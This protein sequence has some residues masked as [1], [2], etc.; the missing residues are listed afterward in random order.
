MILGVDASNVRAGGGLTHLRELLAAAEP[1][2]HGFERVVVWGGRTTLDALSPRPWLDARHIAALDRVL[3]AR[4]AWQHVD[5]PVRARL[6]CDVLF[7][8][9]GLALTPFRPRVLVSQNML[10]FE[11]EERARYGHSLARLRFELLA[12]GQAASFASADGV[13][14]LSDYA[15]RVVSERLG[16]AP[17]RS[18]VI[19]HG[20]DARFRCAPRPPRA[21]GQPLEVLYVSTVSPYKH[22]WNVVDAVGSLRAGGLPVSLRLVGGNDFAPSV[23]RMREAI[24]R[25]DP[26]GLG[27]RYEGVLPFEGLHEAYHRADVF[28]FASSCENLPNILIE[29]MAS[30]LP[31]ACSDR[32]PM[33]EVLG[34]AGL[35]FDPESPESIAHAL[36]RLISEPALR[37]RLAQAA[38]DRAAD[39]GWRR[40]ASETLSFI[41]AAGRGT[42]V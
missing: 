9:G 36:R 30:G 16:A 21:P 10:P 39:Y 23:E 3:P 11:P 38:F 42:H 25:V 8:P 13:I 35:Y 18:A 17:R 2:A 37:S 26:G 28:V 4:L 1:E 27:V 41:G 33:P 19:P 5:L 12:R 40:C 6:G 24:A 22:Q 34:E 15:R 14:F 31:I 20:I 32:G 29:A 7:S